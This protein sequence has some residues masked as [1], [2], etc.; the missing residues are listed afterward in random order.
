MKKI[1]FLIT[2]ALL[3]LI[4]ALSCEKNYL[5]TDKENTGN[6]KIAEDVDVHEDTSDYILDS[7]GADYLVLNGN[8]IITRVA[9]VNVSGNKATIVASGTYKITG[10]LTDGQIIVNTEDNETVWIILDGVNITCLTGPPVFV[11]KAGKVIVFIAD[12]TDNSLTDGTSY[13]ELVDGEPNAALFSKADMTIYGNGSLTIN[14][15]YKNGIS[16]KDG[17]IITSGTIKVIAADDG[18][19]GKDYLIVHDG[20]ITVNSGGDGLK[21]DNTDNTSLGY[22]SIERGTINVTSGGDA[23]AA[24]SNIIINDGYFDIT[25]GGG[26]SRSA[27]ASLSAKGIKGLASVLINGGLIRVSSADDALHS[28]SNITISGGDLTLSSS[29]DGIHA[30]ATIII[31]NCVLNITKSYEGIESKYITV[32]NSM[33]SLISSDD[34]FNATSGAATEMN[35]NSCLSINSG[36]VYVNAST[37]DALDCNGNL[38]IKG[39]TVIV[40]GPAKQ[41]EVGMDYNGVCNISGGT[42]VISGINSNM[43]QAPSTSST[44]YAVL[45]RFTT[46]LAANSLMHVEDINGNEVLTFAPVRSYQSIIFSSA[47]LQ[48]GSTYNIY[49][50]GTYSGMSTNGLYSGGTYSGGTFY[51]S[52]TISGIITTIGS[53]SGGPGSRP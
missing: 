43:T 28:N 30:D 16:C 34:G 15:N 22:I 39:G 40:H 11:S 44:Q 18:I 35:D 13:T 24:Q 48:P 42:L 8:S 25:S 45:I 4:L 20:N 6:D 32:E 36:Y 41:P 38:Y 9:G 19:R 53:A 33:I 2:S 17:L 37:G 5:R 7:A 52:F 26:S 49:T 3:V 21:A 27:S 46:T 10:S 1:L 47:Q 51:K 29:D 31:N 12:S 50:G 14:G 23:L